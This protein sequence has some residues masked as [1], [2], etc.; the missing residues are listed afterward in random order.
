MYEKSCI[1]P[2]DDLKAELTLPPIDGRHCH[3]KRSQVGAE[4]MKPTKKKKSVALGAGL[5]PEK[6]GPASVGRA[7]SPTGK[8][9]MSQKNAQ[10]GIKMKK[11]PELDRNMIGSQQAMRPPKP[12]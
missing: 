7:S 8:L 2:N 5:R 11:L 3:Q 12:Q 9:A 6:E 10:A 4:S 1:T